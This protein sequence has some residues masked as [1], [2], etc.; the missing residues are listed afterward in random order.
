MEHEVE[1]LDAGEDMERCQNRN[2]LKKVGGKN[3]DWAMVEKE[4]REV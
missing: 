2:R 3:G 1:R 4:G